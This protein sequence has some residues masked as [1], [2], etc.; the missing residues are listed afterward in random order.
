MMTNSAYNSYPCANALAVE[1][2]TSALF[3]GA[4]RG[5]GVSLSHAV[6]TVGG[7]APW[8]AGQLAGEPGGDRL[9]NQI[10]DHQF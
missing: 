10:L 6:Q 5:A 8:C 7:L 2:P 1:R 3:K 4:R 9:N